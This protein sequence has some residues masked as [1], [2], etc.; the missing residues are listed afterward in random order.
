M[1]TFMR[2]VLLM[3]ACLLPAPAM[4]ESISASRIEDI[5][6]SVDIDGVAVT[7]QAVIW[8]DMMPRVSVPGVVVRKPGYQIRVTLNAG[9]SR[10]SSDANKTR[11]QVKPERI[12]IIRGNNIWEG[13][14]SQAERSGVEEYSIL[15]GPAWPAGGT[16]DVVVRF[17]DSK[18][19]SH[20]VKAMGVSVEAVH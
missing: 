20:A 7:V 4:A 16:V 14:L 9:A 5:P 11:A 10:M 2:N 13:S 17:V 12:W 19:K 18:K 1:L 6:T 15:N 8:K 3:V